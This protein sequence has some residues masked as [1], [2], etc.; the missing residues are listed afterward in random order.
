MEKW[1]TFL[2]M[3]EA[4]LASKMKYYWSVYMTLFQILQGNYAKTIR[5]PE[6]NINFSQFVKVFENFIGRCFFINCLK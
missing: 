6:P 3:E 1:N 2:L 5:L 4:A